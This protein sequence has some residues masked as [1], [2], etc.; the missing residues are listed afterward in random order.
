MSSIKRQDAPGPT[1]VPTFTSR[2]EMGPSWT[3]PLL[4]DG[5]T[6]I[7]L[8]PKSPRSSGTSRG[9]ADRL[10]LWSHLGDR[11]AD[12]LAQAPGDL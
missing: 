9:A 2:G 11:D 7:H 1:R 8:Q 5:N 6:G 4:Q 10:R 12:S 3:I